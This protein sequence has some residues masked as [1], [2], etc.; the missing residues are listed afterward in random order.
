METQIY[1][2]RTSSAPSPARGFVRGQRERGQGGEVN[3]QANEVSRAG[4]KGQ[5]IWNLM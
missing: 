3:S 2:N 4:G 5:G 1:T